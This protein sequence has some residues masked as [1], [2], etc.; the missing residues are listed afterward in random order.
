MAHPIR[1]EAI[2]QAGP[3][4]GGHQAAA[5]TE[6]QRRLRCLCRFRRERSGQAPADGAVSARIERATNQQRGHER[7]QPAHA[8]VSEPCRVD[9]DHGKTTRVHGLRVAYHTQ[10]EG[11]IG[12]LT[13]SNTCA[14]T[15]VDSSHLSTRSTVAQHGT[16][17]DDRASSPQVPQHP[18]PPVLS[19]PCACLW[20]RQARTSN[21]DVGLKRAMRP[22]LAQAS[23]GNARGP[24][25]KTGIKPASGQ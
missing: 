16:V 14:L 12:R 5:R 8:P 9:S 18:T 15:C 6:R 25:A 24:P 21:H 23:C 3:K 2:R 20:V 7:V 22:R 17:A 10:K 1:A 13:L 19:W 4:N 11:S